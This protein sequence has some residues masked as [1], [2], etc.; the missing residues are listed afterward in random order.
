MIAQLK[1]EIRKLLSVRSTYI[2]ITVAL[3]LISLFTYLGT[4]SS[5]YQEAVCVQ[6]GEV[7]YSQNQAD[8]RLQN[9]SP[10]DVCG[11]TVSYATKT[12]H[13]LPKDKLL[14]NFQE[15]LPLVAIFTSV[16][17]VLF[18]AHEF[19]YNTINYTLT[20]ANSRS[21]VLLSKLLIGVVFTIC[22]TLLAIVLT[23][24]VTNLAIVAKDLT[25]PAQDYNWMYVLFRHLVYALGY[26]LIFIGVAVLVRNLTAGIAAVFLLPT[27]DGLTGFLL[28]IRDIEPTKFLPFS[29]LDRFGNVLL[30]DAQIVLADDFARYPA[31]VLGA[32]VVFSIYL[33]VLWVI[34][35]L[36]FLKRDAN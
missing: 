8:P 14:T 16:V 35:W 34:T 3:G 11:G 10:E 15:T 13:T 20:I 18:V 17:L 29:A 1:S 5:S 2:L 26:T 23:V 31:T 7:L 19:R 22:V 4:S 25:L 32:F 9:A 12:Q 21:K 33:V 6:T 24:V 28:T 36:L 30:S 27:I